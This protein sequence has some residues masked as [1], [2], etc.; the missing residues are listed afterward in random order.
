MRGKRPLVT[1]VPIRRSIAALFAI[2]VALATGCFSYRA[3]ISVDPMAE[4][5]E[6]GSALEVKRA[7]TAVGLAVGG[8][9]MVPDPRFERIARESR[10]SPEIDNIVLG[11]F[12]TGP[13]HDDWVEVRSVVDKR[14]GKFFVM[15]EN[16]ESPRASEL[17]RKVAAAVASVLHEAFPNSEIRVEQKTV[18]PSLGP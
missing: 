1:R 4:P 13:E 14:S 11:L 5:P 8:L 17:T 2:L 3:L 15:V 12:T 10:D 18:G 16:F 7:T 9:G 6:A